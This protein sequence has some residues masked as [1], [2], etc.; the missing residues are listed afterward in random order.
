MASIFVV[1]RRQV[2]GAR[3]ELIRSWPELK[4]SSS[5]RRR[6]GICSLTVRR[7]VLGGALDRDRVTPSV[8]H[9]IV[10]CVHVHRPAGRHRPRHRRSETVA[11]HSSTC[12]VAPAASSICF[13]HSR[14]RSNS[15]ALPLSLSTLSI[16]AS[17]KVFF[18][19]FHAC[20]TPNFLL[21]AISG[22]YHTCKRL[23]S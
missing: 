16:F 13:C 18:T 5:A 2:S 6:D 8:N 19:Q 4:K 21:N 11:Y 12:L 1:P 15:Q 20:L 17:L 14:R 9:S 10:R 23:V 22:L 3:S 7:R